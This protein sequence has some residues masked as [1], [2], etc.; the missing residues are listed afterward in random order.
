MMFDDDDV[1]G[2]GCSSYFLWQNIEQ[3]KA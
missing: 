2:G 1:D 3:R